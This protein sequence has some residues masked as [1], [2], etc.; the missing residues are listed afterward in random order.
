MVDYDNYNKNKVFDELSKSVRDLLSVKVTIPLGDPNLKYL[1]T[2]MMVGLKLSNIFSLKNFDIITN[3]MKSRYSR[4]VLYRKDIWYVESVTINNDGKKFTADIVLNPFPSSIK[5]YA[6]DYEGFIEAFYNAQNQQQN[7]ETSGSGGSVKSASGS[8][9]GGQGDTI[10]NLVR[11]ICGNLSDPLEKCKAIH[12]WLR[13]NVIYQWYECSR[14]GK[15][16]VKCYNNRSHLNCADTATLTCSMMLSAGLNAYVVQRT[17][18][19]GHFWTIIEIG[20]NKYASDQTGRESASMRGSDFNTVWSNSG[21]RNT[22]P[23]DYNKN[24][25][26]KPCC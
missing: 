8:C 10:D 21:R 16:P 12:E 26:S 22:N 6:D 17:Y 9:P 23:F 19:G 15:D 5:S 11:S 14:Y 13:G 3:E 4:G 18:N 7:G 25:G 2:N 20:G 24:C 1:H